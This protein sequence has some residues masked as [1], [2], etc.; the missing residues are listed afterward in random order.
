MNHYPSEPD[1]QL[2]RRPRP[3]RLTDVVTPVHVVAQ[4]C[5]RSV[6]ESTYGFRLPRPAAHED[7]NR[8][9]TGAE[10]L[11][12]YAASRGLTS[13]GGLPDET[14]AGRTILKDFTSGK[15]L[16]CVVPPGSSPEKLGLPGYGQQQPLEGLAGPSGRRGGGEEASGRGGSDEEEDGEEEDSDGEW[17]SDEFEGAAAGAGA[18][19]DDSDGED[20]SEDDDAGDDAG[21]GARG[22]PASA[23]SGAFFAAGKTGRRV[24]PSEMDASELDRTL[25]LE[26]QAL[27][28]LNKARARVERTSGRFTLSALNLAFPGTQAPAD[29]S[30][31]FFAR[32]LTATPPP[33]CAARCAGWGRGQG[34]G[35]SAAQAAEEG[36]EGEDEA[37]CKGTPGAAPPLLLLSSSLSRLQALS[38]QP[39]WSS[40]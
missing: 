35:P 37:P 1:S 9:P 39:R 6:L 5:P 28:V 3:R 24:A 26:M 22:G 17:E 12:C 20:E 13:G 15:L 16:H 2:L 18:A 14:R 8:Q 11:R 21:D 4:R 34:C 30:W 23:L 25:L 38:A 33:S 32:E 36:E 19:E 31:C 27:G 40:I 10:L 7:Q 29:F